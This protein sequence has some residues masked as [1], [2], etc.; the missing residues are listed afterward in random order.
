[1]QHHYNYNKTKFIKNY[2]SIGV[3]KWSRNGC[4]NDKIINNIS[5]DIFGILFLKAK[6]YKKIQ[7]K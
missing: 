4:G 3:K 2:Y 5:V 7:V 6:V 1:M